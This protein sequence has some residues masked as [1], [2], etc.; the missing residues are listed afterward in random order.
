MTEEARK[1]SEKS[2]LDFDDLCRI[3]RLLRAEGGCLWDRAQTHASVRS[4]VIE[5]AYEVVEAIDRNDSELLCEELG[6]LLFQAVFHAQM[7]AEAGRFGIGDVVDRNARKMIDRHPQ[8]FGDEA[9]TDADEAL[10][11]W[12]ARKTAEKGRVTKSARLRAVPA[13]LPALMRAQKVAKKAGLTEGTS[14][15]AVAASVGDALPGLAAGDPA[16]IGQALFDLCRLAALSGADAE[17]CLTRVTERV[18]SG[19]ENSE[20]CVKN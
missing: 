4:C 19:V 6:D 12:E 1:L 16:A 8:V 3:T 18:I 17:E 5:E 14:P 11:Q 2:R 7:E 20:N 10:R 15:A 13:M 9:A